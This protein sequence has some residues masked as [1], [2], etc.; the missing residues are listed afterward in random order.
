MTP[1]NKPWQDFNMHE[2]LDIDDKPL[3]ET[4]KLKKDIFGHKETFLPTQRN[5]YLHMYFQM[6]K[7]SQQDS[8]MRVDELS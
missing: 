7:C 3:T 2:V 8:F 6:N 1:S 4:D 5:L